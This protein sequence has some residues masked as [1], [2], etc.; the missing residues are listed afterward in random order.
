MIEISIRRVTGADL[1]ALQQIGRQTFYE[2]FSE[3][4]TP[5]NMAAYLAEAFSVAK[6]S[7]ELN[8]P[9]TEF[10]F[11]FSGRELAAYL[12][13]NCG[14]AQIEENHVNSME[15]ERIY[16]LQKFQRQAVGQALLDHA[17][18][19]AAKSRFSYLWLGVWEENPKAIRFYQKNGFQEFD[20]HIFRL[21]EDEQ[22][23]ILMRRML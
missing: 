2:T 18:L 9:G 3:A 23:D 22:T 13:L 5:E 14:S 6:L 21:G 10:Y 11:A 19:V 20:K 12:K 4:N 8:E 7:A 16:V 1:E 17:L 15:I